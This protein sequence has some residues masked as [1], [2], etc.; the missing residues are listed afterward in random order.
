MSMRI[1]VTGASGFL[2]GVLT[3]RLLSR[4][5]GVIAVGRD[6]A[7]LAKLARLD[8][9]TLALDLSAP[10][11][12]PAQLTCD[13][14]V[15]C[16][17]LSSPWGRR[18]DFFK[19]NVVGTQSALRLAEHA[20]ARRFVHISTPS[21]Y[22]RFQDQIGV[23]EDAPLPRP[24]NA[25]AETK[26]AAEGLVLAAR[27][28]DSIVLR[29]RGLYGAGDTTLLPRL[30]AAARGRALPLMNDGRAATDLTYVGDVAHAICAALIVP[31]QK[32]CIF[33]ISGG[34]AL[35]VRE[36]AER[37]AKRAGVAVRWRRA[38]TA[39]VLAYARACEAF[40]GLLPHHPEPPITA[41][42]AGLF[43]FSQTLDIS[44]AKAQ[45][46]WTP[47]TNFDEGLELAFAGEPT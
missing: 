45:L 25:Y 15:H 27:G 10:E 18:A 47:R 21:L 42:G 26:R 43:A 30:V 7:K 33:N 22:F 9:E 13:A 2:G 16:A 28:L 4:G 1:L 39:A 17:A 46:G 19:A 35:N 37:A 32:Q 12:L 11:S 44:A 20:G 31:P 34:Q 8:A 36:I 5:H 29:P 24:V 40:C 23:R 3:R 6:H 14:T 38:P 41:Y